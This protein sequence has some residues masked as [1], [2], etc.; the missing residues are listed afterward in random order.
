MWCV[1]IPNDLRVP[2]CSFELLF[3]SRYFPIL[4]G[5]PDFSFQFCRLQAQSLVVT[6][7]CVLQ[8]R[9]IEASFAVPYGSKPDK[10]VSRMQARKPVAVEQGTK[11]EGF[12]VSDSESDQQENEEAAEEA[13]AK[14]CMLQLARKRA[15][16]KRKQVGADP[17][18]DPPPTPGAASSGSAPT[19]H[20]PSVAASASA[21]G[22]SSGLA[23][24]SGEQ[25]PPPLPPPPK[26]PRELRKHLWCGFGLAPLKVHGYGATCALHKNEWDKPG[27]VCK[28]SISVQSMS[29]DESRLRMKLWLL[30]GMEIDSDRCDA[31]DAHRIIEAPKLEVM[32]EDEVDRQ[33]QVCGFHLYFHFTPLAPIYRALPSSWPTGDLI[34]QPAPQPGQEVVNISS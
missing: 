9:S 14:L 15:S 27:T 5:Q 25:P 24:G 16:G 21:S 12:S 4:F 34:G 11:S 6:I 22:S 10:S 19:R 13:V 2:V 30:R 7:C 20:T 33:M 32:S 26:E 31:R 8:A 29:I 3:G 1:A 17:A 23:A 18:D 28:K